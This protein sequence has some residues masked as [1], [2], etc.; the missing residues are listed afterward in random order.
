MHVSRN[1]PRDMY[2]I[3]FLLHRQ[4]QF[5]LNFKKILSIIKKKHS[6]KP[7]YKMIKDR[8]K[9]QQHWQTRLQKQIADLPDQHI[10]IQEILHYLNK[11]ADLKDNDSD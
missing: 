8:L 9:M 2:D 1:E 6:F 10:V 7:T 11:Y 5:E 3:W 4:H